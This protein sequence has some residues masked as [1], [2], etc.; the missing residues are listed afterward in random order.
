MGPTHLDAFKYIEQKQITL[1]QTYPDN[2]KRGLLIDAS[3]WLTHQ[4]TIFERFNEW[5]L[6][7]PNA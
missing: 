5:R 3:Y 4:D 7:H 6:G 2:L 1:L